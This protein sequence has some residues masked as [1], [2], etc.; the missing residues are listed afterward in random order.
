TAANNSGQTTI[1]STLLNAT[2]AAIG[3]D[4]FGAFVLGGNTYI[5]GTNQT[6]NFEDDLLLRINGTFTLTTADFIL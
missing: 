1:N 6:T 4:R 2:A 5:Q 3:Q